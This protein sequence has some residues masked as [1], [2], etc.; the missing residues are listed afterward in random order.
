MAFRKKISEKLNC[1][2]KMTRC[3]AFFGL[4]SNFY[5]SYYIQYVEGKKLA[6]KVGHTLK[7]RSSGGKNGG[8]NF[9]VFL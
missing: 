8:K 1:L 6:S 4:L 3:K 5:V 2:A 9:A 7:R